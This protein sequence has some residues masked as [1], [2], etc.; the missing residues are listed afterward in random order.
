MP[1]PIEVPILAYAAEG[2]INQVYT[3]SS[4][5]PFACM[6]S[7]GYAIYLVCL[8]V[9][10]FVFVMTCNKV[11]KKQYQ[12]QGVQSYTGLVLKYKFP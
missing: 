4:I 8:S 11:P 7:E 3:I 6:C 5:Y 9:A 2:E 12:G 1:K 10:R